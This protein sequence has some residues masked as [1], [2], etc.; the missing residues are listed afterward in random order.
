MLSGCKSPVEIVQKII[1][2]IRTNSDTSGDAKETS[3]EIST[4]NFIEKDSENNEVHGHLY[5]FTEEEAPLWINENSQSYNKSLHTILLPNNKNFRLTVLDIFNNYD[6]EKEYISSIY[7]AYIDKGIEINIEGTYS[8]LYLINWKGYLNTHSE[9]MFSDIYSDNLYI[10]NNPNANYLKETIS[11]HQK[12]LFCWNGSSFKELAGDIW[13]LGIL[14]KGS[15]EI[16]GVIYDKLKLNESK[17]ERF[18]DVIFTV[19]AETHEIVKIKCNIDGVK[20]LCLEYFTGDPTI[21]ES[22]SRKEEK[23]LIS[24]FSNNLSGAKEKKEEFLKNKR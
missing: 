24:A 21:D 15:E 20:E 9:G 6:G 8:A 14:Y 10:S 17:N 3:V 16:D 19:N 23:D 7:T 1:T 22:I 2:A 4:I 11:S 5:N 18:S 13:H 12:T